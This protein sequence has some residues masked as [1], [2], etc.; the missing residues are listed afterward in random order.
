MLPDQ[1][2]WLE[3]GCE[4]ARAPD[5]AAGAPAHGSADSKAS[6]TASAAA[7]MHDTCMTR[8]KQ[9]VATACCLLCLQLTAGLHSTA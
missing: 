5:E 1:E 3:P 9:A 7:R 2:R 8:A 6:A 4:F